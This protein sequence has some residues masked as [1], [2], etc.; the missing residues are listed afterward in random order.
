MIINFCKCC[1][2]GEIE[3]LDYYCQKCWEAECCRAWWEMISSIEDWEV[4]FILTDSSSEE[5]D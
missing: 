4:E 3:W 1:E 2:K 5:I